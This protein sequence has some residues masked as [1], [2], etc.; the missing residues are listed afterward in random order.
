MA[1]QPFTI[2]TASKRDVV[3]CRLYENYTFLFVLLS[4]KW[5][6]VVC[7]ASVIATLSN[8]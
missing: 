2:E 7:K 4:T 1:H 3:Y 8:L 5:M 6:H